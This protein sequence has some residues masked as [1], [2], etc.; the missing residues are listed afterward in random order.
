MS[1]SI[2]TSSTNSGRYLCVAFVLLE[3][4]PNLQ[5]RISKPALR[6]S[7]QEPP[8]G[9]EAQQHCAWDAVPAGPFPGVPQSLAPSPPLLPLGLTRQNHSPEHPRNFRQ[10]PGTVTAD[11]CLA[12]HTGCQVL[13][14]C[15][16]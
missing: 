16:E 8:L 3:P 1:S 6:G 12:K 15:S 13:A 11:T 9:P 10:A 7:V 14:K 4:C 2:T 5:A